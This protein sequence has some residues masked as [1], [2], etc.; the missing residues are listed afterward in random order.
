M[1]TSDN[2]DT[3]N[4][5]N[6]NEVHVESVKSIRSLSELNIKSSDTSK[7][8]VPISSVIYLMMMMIYDDL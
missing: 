7:R 3:N 5:S 8:C 1:E 4:D 2:T 6:D